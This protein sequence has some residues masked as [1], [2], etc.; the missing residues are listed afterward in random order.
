MTEKMITIFSLF[1][2][3]YLSIIGFAVL[4]YF[5]RGNN[6]KLLTKSFFIIFGIYA[7]VLSVRSFF[8][9]VSLLKTSRE[10]VAFSYEKKIE[11]QAGASFELY[12]NKMN[13]HLKNESLVYLVNQHDKDFFYARMYL[14]PI[15]V[16]QLSS[17]DLNRQA[18]YILSDTE[19]IF[20]PEKYIKAEMMGKILVDTRIK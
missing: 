15:S 6:R 9:E 3:F 4:W 17:I 16:Q 5:L 12:Y 13:E 14:Y 2:W 20:I 8:D 18:L 10:T 19:K 1:G 11:C 7:C